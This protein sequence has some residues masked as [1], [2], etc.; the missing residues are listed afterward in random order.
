MNINMKIYLN[1]N[2]KKQYCLYIISLLFLLVSGCVPVP[3]EVRSETGLYENIMVEKSDTTKFD[4]VSLDQ[5]RTETTDWAG[6]TY[7]QIQLPKQ[8]QLPNSNMPILDMGHFV[9]NY[10]QCDALQGQFLPDYSSIA[11]NCKESEKRINEKPFEG[12]DNYNYIDYSIWDTQPCNKEK[13]MYTRSLVL[14]NKGYFFYCNGW[15][16]YSQY[17]DSLKREIAIHIGEDEIPMQPYSLSGQ[18]E[19]IADAISYTEHTVNQWMKTTYG[20][21]VYDYHVSWFYVLSDG[22]NCYYSMVL[23]RTYKGLPFDDAPCYEIETEDLYNEQN[24]LY[25]SYPMVVEMYKPNTIGFIREEY[26]IIP[27][28][29]KPTESYLSLSSAIKLASSKLANKNIFS[30]DNVSLCYTLRQENLTDIETGKHKYPYMVT[31]NDWA[32][33]TVTAR[34][35]W[36]FYIER[37][38]YPKLNPS[39]R[40]NGRNLVVLIDAID[41]TFQYYTGD[42]GG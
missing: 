9:N 16:N 21:K 8:I 36:V 33:T 29:Q 18:E 38:R 15:E 37:D 32:D 4:Y 6:K 39:S 7:N 14:D 3:E 1:N 34:P 42:W 24:Y 40:T 25:G 12:W 2:Q 26:S 10:S 11:D 35:T 13:D 41:G 23:N 30:F 17:G 22:T 19:S 20:Q 31:L 28:E 27:T 5:L